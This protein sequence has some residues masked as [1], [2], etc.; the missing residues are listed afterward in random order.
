MPAVLER[1]VGA[2]IG[3]CTAGGADGAE[4]T[5]LNDMDHPLESIADCIAQVEARIDSVWALHGLPIS[6][7]PPRRRPD[8]RLI[9]GGKQSEGAP[10]P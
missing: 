4:Q 6:F 3:G 1:S 8:L 10:K 9:I 7:A 2:G 5:V